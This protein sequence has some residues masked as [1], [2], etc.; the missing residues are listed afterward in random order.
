MAIQGSPP[1]PCA[2]LLERRKARSSYGPARLF[3]KKAL[4]EDCAAPH[5]KANAK[6]SSAS[7]FA[8]RLLPASGVKGGSAPKVDLTAR[9][10]APSLKT[11]SRNR[12]A[13][14]TGLKDQPKTAWPSDLEAR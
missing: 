14:E 2:R 11:F 6:H 1:L 3:A 7:C 9:A 5:P 10:K 4:S 13:R 12:Q 8:R